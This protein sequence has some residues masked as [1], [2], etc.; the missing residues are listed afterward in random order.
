M[1]NNGRNGMGRI[2]L[3][4]G[5]AN[6]TG[7]ILGDRIVCD[8]KYVEGIQETE[9]FSIDVNTLD[10]PTKYFGRAITILFTMG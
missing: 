1:A 9:K 3:H 6:F 2:Y 8:N 7:T 10:D 4:N 5:D